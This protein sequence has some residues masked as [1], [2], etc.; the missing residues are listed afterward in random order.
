[1]SQKRKAWPNAMVTA[2]A[3]VLPLF[4]S[5]AFS[6]TPSKASSDI[7]KAVI[8]VIKAHPEL[9]RDA[10]N[11]LERRDTVAKAQQEAI[12]LAKSSKAIFSDTGAV[13]LGNPNG[14]ITLVEFMDYHCGYCKKMSVGLDELIQ[15]DPQ[16]RVLVKQLPILGAESVAAAQLMLSAGQG[17]TAQ[18]VHQA[19]MNSQKL[20][21]ASLRSIEQSYQL[22]PTDKISANR[23]LGE[24]RV[25][26]EQLNIQGTPALVIG[27]TVFRGAVE[28]AQLEAAIST[29]RSAQQKQAKAKS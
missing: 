25:L 2:I 12:T 10:L 1:M 29:A 16:L 4:S 3:I 18:Q 26:A 5:S 23:A 17:Q 9:V 21:A 11:E 13:V 14:D 24:V 28:T 6:Q 15:R 27:T 7:E 20:D 19:L 22:K 8:K